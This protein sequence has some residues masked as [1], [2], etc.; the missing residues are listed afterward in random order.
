MRIAGT[1]AG[2]AIMMIAA[3]PS[4]GSFLIEIPVEGLPAFDHTFGARNG[5]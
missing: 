2:V 3:A 4:C 5:L 1:I